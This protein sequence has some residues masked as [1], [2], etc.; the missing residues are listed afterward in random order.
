MSGKLSSPRDLFLQSLA[1]MLWIERMLVFEV[2]PDLQK[3][4]KS[5]TL[6]AAVEGHLA[7]THDHVA[8]IER[9]F[10][11]LGAEPA[12]A[13]SAPAAALKEEHQ[14]VSTKI[15]EPRLADLYHA[16]SA[17][18]TEHLE[19]AAY[20]LLIDL[21]GSFAERDVVE[22]LASNRADEEAALERLRA[23]AENL[24]SEARQPV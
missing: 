3:Q 2:L 18:Q 15:A 1:Q 10:V 21:A 9:I 14:E 4:V 22:L 20:D 16:G 5:E 19:I 23:L 13:R 24:R 11:A 12:S 17:Q 6:A 8:R 7:Q